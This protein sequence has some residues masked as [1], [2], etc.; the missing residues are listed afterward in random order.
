MPYFNPHRHRQILQGTG[1]TPRNLTGIEF[2]ENGS[3]DRRYVV[4]GIIEDTRVEGLGAGST[5][6]QE[7][8][9]TAKQHGAHAVLFLQAAR[10]FRGTDPETGSRYYSRWSKFQAIQYI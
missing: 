4:V 1:G 6:D 5:R 2:W 7:V 10:D 8:A 3:P 9:Q